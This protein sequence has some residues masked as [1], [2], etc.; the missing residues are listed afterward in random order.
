MG[1]F[2][3]CR[4]RRKGRQIIHV[5]SL[6]RKAKGKSIN[7]LTDKVNIVMK[8]NGPK[9]IASWALEIEHESAC[10]DKAMLMTGDVSIFFR[11]VPLAADSCGKFSLYLVDLDISL[12]NLSLPFGW[13]DS[14]AFYW[15]AGQAIKVIQNQRFMNL[16]WCDDHIL[17]EFRLAWRMTAAAHSLRRAMVLVLGVPKLAMMTN[18][19][20]GCANVKLWV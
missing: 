13:T 2:Q 1:L 19:H 12:V 9:P 18:S 5:A 11:N 14:P 4:R 17:M 8:Y 15:L 7:S 6:P 20:L 3:P 16:L 10:P